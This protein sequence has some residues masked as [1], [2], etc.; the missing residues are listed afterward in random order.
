MARCAVCLVELVSGV[1][2]FA[3][4]EQFVVHRRCINGNIALVTELQHA[5][6][7]LKVEIRQKQS[8]IASGERTRTNMQALIDR[9]EAAERVARMAHDEVLREL[10]GV[11]ADLASER[12][13]RTSLELQLEIARGS[14]E[15]LPPPGSDEKPISGPPKS[16]QEIRTTLLELD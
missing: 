1:D 14:G 12:S 8:L 16:D 7:N 10:A 13:R 3:F 5:H 9:A 15:K 4:V 6:D 11:R 2:K